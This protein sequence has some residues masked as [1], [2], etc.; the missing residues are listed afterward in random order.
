VKA[1]G[2]ILC[3]LAFLLILLWLAHLASG[4]I[5]VPI[6]RTLPSGAVED[7][8][9]TYVLGIL[10]RRKTEIIPSP[11]EAKAQAQA[12]AQAQAILAPGKREN[13][14]NLLFLCAAGACL[15]LSV[16]SVVVAVLCEGWKRFGIAAA[17]FLLTGSVFVGMEI[18]R[19]SCR[20]RV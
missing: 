9:E 4:C 10:L 8:Y 15:L 2:R 19:A 13:R 11:E 20:E 18:G 6:H 3:A 14:A 16:L 17:V 1:T 5:T 7:G 12:Q